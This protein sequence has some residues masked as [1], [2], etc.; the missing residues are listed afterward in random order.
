MT[1]SLTA[2]ATARGLT[3]VPVSLNPSFRKIML[4]GFDICT[5][6]GLHG[7]RGT[8]S[9]E[10]Q[11]FYKGQSPQEGDFIFT[12]LDSKQPG[13]ALDGDTASIF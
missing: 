8:L 1:W 11:G 6:S 12:V 9:W 13:F 2:L 10:T 7:R 5:H 3:L 4:R